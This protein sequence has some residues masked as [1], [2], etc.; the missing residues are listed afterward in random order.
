ME[1]LLNPNVIYCL[2]AVGFTLVVLAI[3]TPGTGLLEAGALV[4]LLAAGW[5]AFQLS[6]NLWALAVLTIGAVLFV[7][8]AIRSR[9]IWFSALSTCVIIVGSLFLFTGEN[10]APGVNPV[11]AVFV[12]ALLAVFF[13]VVTRKGLLAVEGP[14]QHDLENLVGMIGEARTAIDQDGTILL[15]SEL[16]SARSAQPLPAGSTVRVVGREGFILIVE[17]VPSE[18]RP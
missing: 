1:L 17:G 7:V 12:S 15:E 5:G 11:L 18:D 13:W 6:L 14:K 9:R 8:G 2:L 10:G 3:L 16:W 4:V